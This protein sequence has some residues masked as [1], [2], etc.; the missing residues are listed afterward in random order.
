MSF[1]SDHMDR[2]AESVLAQAE[3]ARTGA[4]H[5]G[6]KGA[7]IEVILRNVLRQYFPSTFAVGTGQIANVHGELSPQ[8]DVLLYDMSVFP[9]L[10]VNED[11][12][13]VVCAE[14]VYAVVEAKAAWKQGD[15]ESHFDRFRMVDQ[16]RSGPWLNVQSAGYFIFF[17]DTV[18]HPGM[19]SLMDDQRAVGVYS[20]EGKRGWYSPRNNQ[21]F[22]DH[23]GNALELFLRHAL[24]DCMEKGQIEVGTLGESY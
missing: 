1:L 10:S 15:I 19:E 24:Q 20:L 17:I 11:G 13:V 2:L 12:S 3:R 16:K 23:V 8:M 7:A 5:S 9:R 6:I 14:S 18:V 22:E 4:E 21:A